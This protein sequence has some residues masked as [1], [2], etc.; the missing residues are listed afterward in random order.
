MVGPVAFVVRFYLGADEDELHNY[1]GDE[2]DDP[3][4]VVIE[5]EEIGLLWVS[6]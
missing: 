5:E 3:P 2:V 6:P 1:K 4:G